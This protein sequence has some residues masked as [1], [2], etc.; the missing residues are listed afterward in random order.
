[1]AYT[2]IKL[3]G[4]PWEYDPEQPIGKAGGFGAVY[5]GT[6]PDGAAVAVKRLHIGAAEAAHR[7]LRLAEFL[8]GRDLRNVMPVLDYGQDAESEGYFIVMPRAE[9]S[10]QNKLDEDGPVGEAEVVKITRAIV[11]GLSEVPDIV[12]RDLKPDNILFLD[13][14]WRI[15]D[16]GIAKFVEESTSA[17]TLKGAL[18]PYYAAP[19]QWDLAK[20][21]ET[22]D[23]Y[24][25]GCIAVAL[26]NG[27]PPYDGGLEE[28]RDQHLHKDPPTINV[29]P[30]LGSIIRQM[31][32]KSPLARPSRERVLV[33]LDKVQAAERQPAG[34][35]V[36]RLA[37][38]AEQHDAKLAREEAERERLQSAVRERRALADEAR[39]VLMEIAEAL[40]DRVIEGIPAASKSRE[41]GSISARL[42][43]VKLEIDTATFEFFEQDAFP[44]SEWDVVCGG[45]IEVV[46]AN[47]NHK[48]AANLWFTRRNN[49]N[50]DYRWYEVGYRCTPGMNERFEF[51]PTAVAPDVADT[52]HW[53]ALAEFDAAYAPIS[54]D[55]E[56][57]DAFCE[58]WIDYLA[59]AAEKKLPQLP[60]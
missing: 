35:G 19:E 46:Q 36:D 28:L 13:G 38:A 29:G 16:F 2:V 24:S 39:V 5:Q 4:G 54:I 10:L 58:R 55:G 51:E 6:G 32:R 34:G 53:V 50:A 43:D 52:A 26:L 11:S 23:I 1:M 15:A 45:V 44:K 59:A 30:R 25:L 21:T 33:M 40:V 17:R 60:S 12:H 18:S 3:E 42:T 48:R 49:Q 57:V 8:V 22:T 31:L 14:T 56:D 7:E 47:P 37:A 20:A 27:L 41:G 9:Y